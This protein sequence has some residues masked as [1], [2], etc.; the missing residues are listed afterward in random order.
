ML[1]GLLGDWWPYSAAWTVSVMIPTHHLY[2]PRHRNLL[3]SVLMTRYMVCC[4]RPAAHHPPNVLR[5]RWVELVSIFTLIKHSLYSFPK[6]HRKK[7]VS[8]GTR[9]RAGPGGPASAG[10]G[11][12]AG[13][14]RQGARS[15][16]LTGQR[17][18][19]GTGAEGPAGGRCG[20]RCG[21]RWGQ[22]WGHRLCRVKRLPQLPQPRQAG[23]G[24]PRGATRTSPGVN[25]CGGGSAEAVRAGR[26][27]SGPPGCQRDHEGQNRSLCTAVKGPLYWLREWNLLRLKPGKINPVVQLLQLWAG[28]QCSLGN[29]CS[30]F[31][32]EWQCSLYHGQELRDPVKVIGTARKSILL[33]TW[34]K[35]KSWALAVGCWLVRRSS[36]P[37]SSLLP[38]TQQRFVS[39]LWSG[40]FPDNFFHCILQNQTPSLL[41]VQS[42][43]GTAQPWWKVAETTRILV[44]LPWRCILQPSALTSCLKACQLR[45]HCKHDLI[46]CQKLTLSY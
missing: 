40:Q 8:T 17:L 23:G 9:S 43:V 10:W 16:G 35:S 27:T 37:V 34:R 12:G 1:K 3:S 7:R 4:S 29:P 39:F 11:A 19:G 5:D 44:H 36:S 26:G 41:R 15:A 45:I 28:G 38:H 21:H 30:C 22:R 33:F 18:R 46:L 24:E 32:S 31:T 13:S 14:G 42:D 2:V 25:A 6:G 20:H